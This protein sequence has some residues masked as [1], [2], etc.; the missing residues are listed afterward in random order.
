MNA[1]SF[2]LSLSVLATSWATFKGMHDVKWCNPQLT[3]E[4]K[5][6]A[7]SKFLRHATVRGLA[8]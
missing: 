3:V 8:K 5:P 7:G 1:L 4:V 2:S 6:L